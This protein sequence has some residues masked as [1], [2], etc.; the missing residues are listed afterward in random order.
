[1][2]SLYKSC[3]AVHLLRHWL[4]TGTTDYAPIRKDIL[5]GRQVWPL[6]SARSPEMT[7]R[8]RHPTEVQIAFVDL[9]KSLFTTIRQRQIS[10]VTPLFI[11]LIA[12]DEYE[13]CVSLVRV[14]DDLLR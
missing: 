10:L 11:A 5:F 7:A 1:V 6:S 3:S 8:R 14:N 13:V 12:N 2:S 9:Y 4:Y